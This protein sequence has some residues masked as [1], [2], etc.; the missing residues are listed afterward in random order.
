MHFFLTLYFLTFVSPSRVLDKRDDNLYLFC[1]KDI[2]RIIIK[3]WGGNYPWF[4]TLAYQPFDTLKFYFHS[5]PHEYYILHVCVLINI[6]LSILLFLPQL[7]LIL[8]ILEVIYL[9]FVGFPHTIAFW[10][11]LKITWSTAIVRPTQF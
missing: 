4:Y 7:C 1:W 9:T 3:V 5:F 10:Y 8:N 2:I 6:L 11:S